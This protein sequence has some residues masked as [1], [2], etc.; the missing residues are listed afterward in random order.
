MAGGPGSAREPGPAPRPAPARRAST[1]MA[2]PGGRTWRPPSRAPLKGTGG[3]PCPGQGPR[4]SAPTRVAGG[5]GQGPRGRPARAAPRRVWRTRCLPGA[6]RRGA[7]A[8]RDWP[9][10]AAPPLAEPPRPAASEA[11]RVP[12]ARRVPLLRGLTRLRNGCACGERAP[13]LKAGAAGGVPRVTVNGSFRGRGEEV[14]ADPRTASGR[15][16]GLLGTKRDAGA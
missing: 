1:P 12:A 16:G 7:R 10:R 2:P 6:G 8:R 5:A 3:A 15:T 14:H 13:P 11:E 9:S 4:G